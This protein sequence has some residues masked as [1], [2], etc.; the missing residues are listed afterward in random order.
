MSQVIILEINHK[1][2]QIYNFKG[3]SE[4]KSKGNDRKSVQRWRKKKRRRKRKRKIILKV[5]SQGLESRL[6]ELGDL[7]S[8][9]L[10]RLFDYRP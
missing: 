4:L 7:S 8:K 2:Q 6:E 9:E 10:E 5:I 1:F 3:P